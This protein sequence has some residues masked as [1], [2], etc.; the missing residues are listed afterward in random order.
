[1]VFGLFGGGNDREAQSKELLS[2][3]GNSARV[4]ASDGSMIDV[5]V[6]GLGMMRVFL[7][8]KFPGE[9][10][11]LQLMQP[12]EHELVDKY[13]Q[14]RSP[15]LARWGAKSKLA[16]VVVAVV[17][18][19][20]SHASLVANER[21]VADLAAQRS[22]ASAPAPARDEPR[23]HAPMPEI[24][25]DFP[26]LFDGL[27][28]AALDAL[29]ADPEALE[30]AVDRVAVLASMV[31]LRGELRA[32]NLAAARAA[33]VAADDADAA[34][35][36]AQTAADDL[37]DALAAYDAA[38]ADA[39]RFASSDPAGDAAA[40]AAARSKA[41]DAKSLALLDAWTGGDRA[42]F[43]EAYIAARKEHHLEAA[44]AAQCGR[45]DVAVEDVAYLSV[46]ENRD[47][48]GIWTL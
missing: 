22:L 2:A 11:V 19:L 45:P 27:D 29:V 4:A 17:D 41:A 43:I 14:V 48:R 36:E 31:S 44:L 8:P 24:P 10:P 6:K 35:R 20:E 30:A 21:T 47:V 9:R 38:R 32:S 12:Y 7:P 5:S 13:S 3:L 1:M 18:A 46:H 39:A 25:G 37:R 34:Q 23:D 40:G 15:A 28:D 42:Q 16:D 26:E 33:L